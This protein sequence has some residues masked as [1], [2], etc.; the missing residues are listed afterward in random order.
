M[1]DPVKSYGPGPFRADDLPVGSPYELS[2]GHPIFCAPAGGRH[3]RA[4]VAGATA[5]ATD[6]AVSAPGIEPSYRIDDRTVRSPDVAIGN[7]PDVPGQVPGAPP[8][9]LEYASIGQDEAEL[10][11]KIE[12]LLDAGTRWVWVVRL[13]GPRRV[14]VHE[15]GRAMVVVPD[16]EVLRAPGVLANDVPVTALFD[17][18]VANE[19][20]LRNLLQR[21]GY[22]SVEAI[23]EEGRDEGVR[24]TLRKLL[25]VRFGALPDSAARRLDAA[26]RSDLDRW[27]ER[28]FDATSL[29]AVLAD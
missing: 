8:L 24:A 17:L 23:R 21:H 19:V 13:R 3:A 7:V 4:A 27:L 14:E 18:D 15:R 20:A 6:P 1:G 9:A 2:N 16:G 26:S 25:T 11:A 12:E 29:D 28:V 22:G 10:A 5:L